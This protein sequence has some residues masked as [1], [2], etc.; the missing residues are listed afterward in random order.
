MVEAGW[1][2]GRD[3]IGGRVVVVVVYDTPVRRPSEMV[4]MNLQMV[5]VLRDIL[6][7]AVLEWM[8]QSGGGRDLDGGG[9]GKPT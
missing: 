7:D 9:D 6:S 2:L 8:L 4:P 3:W 5:A 1:A